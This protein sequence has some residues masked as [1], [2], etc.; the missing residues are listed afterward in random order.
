M[1]MF[2]YLQELNKP[3]EGEK[4]YILLRKKCYE[5]TKNNELING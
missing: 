4:K 2:Q 1:L 3:Y 5:H